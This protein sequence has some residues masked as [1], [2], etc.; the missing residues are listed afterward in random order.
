MNS[1]VSVDNNERLVR[2]E[3][4]VEHQSEKIEDM[5]SKMNQMYD[6]FMQAKGARWMFLA[7]GVAVGSFIVNLKT[8]LSFIGIKIGS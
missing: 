3:M 2:L 1:P 5:S 4:K 8:L 7:A 6:V